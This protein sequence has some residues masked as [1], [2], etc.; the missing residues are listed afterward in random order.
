[1]TAQVCGETPLRVSSPRAAPVILPV[2]NA[3]FPKA[4]AATTSRI[5]ANL[6]RGLP[7]VVRSASPR[8]SR[9]TTPSRALISCSTI[10]AKIENITAHR[11]A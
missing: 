5:A 10:V 11:R 2:W 3:A 8:P 6:M 4:I 1:M 7:N 9:L